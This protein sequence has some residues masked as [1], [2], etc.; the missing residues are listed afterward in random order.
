MESLTGK[1]PV[2]NLRCHPLFERPSQLN[3]G[4]G[5]TVRLEHLASAERNALL[6]QL[7]E[8]LPNL[9]QDPSPV[10]ALIELLVRPTN[11][12]F[13]DILG[14]NPP[15]DFSA[16]LSAPH[17]A[18]NLVTLILLHKASLQRS[19]AGI[20]AG[21]PNVVSS[22]VRLWLSTADIAVAQKAH[23]VLLGLLTADERIQQPET[24]AH[25]NLREPY[26]HGLMWR[27]LFKDKDIYG[28]MFSMC[29]LA[30]AGQP[31]QLSKNQKSAAQ[32]RLLDM[33]VRLD[34]ESIRNSQIPEVEQRYGIQRGGILDF[35]ATAM[36]DRDDVLMHMLLVDFYAELLPP[37]HS[38]VKTSEIS[39]PT[40]HSSS[41][42]DFLIDRGLHSRSL[43]YYLEP[44]RHSSMDVTYL[45]SRSANYLSVYA[46]L[47]PI[48]FL[49]TASATADATLRRLSDVF[50]RMSAATWAHAQVPTHDLHVLASLPRP[51]LFPRPTPAP[52]LFDIPVTPANADAYNVLATVFRGPPPDAS[53]D[54]HPGASNTSGLESSSA[55]AL[56][57]LYLEQRPDMWVH[58][59]KAAETVA[60]KDVAIAAIG[61]I[62][63]VITANW[64]LLSESISSPKTEMP[65]EHQL[66]ERCHTHQRLPLSGALAMLTSP[67]LETVLPFLFRPPRLFSN[68]V[69]GGKG[70]VESAAYLVAA[71]KYATAKRLRDRVNELV[72]ET[73][74][75]SDVVSAL[76]RRLAVGIMGGTGEVGGRVGTLEL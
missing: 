33:L 55:R 20:V 43:S 65:T 6:N 58:I 11:Y 17:S 29:D 30:T 5:L 49:D 64:S 67:S 59:V 53:Q 44:N 37:G 75:F 73:G 4:L 40:P 2:C 9:Q 69:G 61:L 1:L 36:V 68:L 66:S 63:A 52:P 71:A 25:E 16:G 28:S 21:K 26:H 70:D 27:R 15:V 72:E 22:L 12:T 46:S 42:L 8:L 3:V 50:F 47:Y 60:I 13:S 23:D 14:I 74:Q 19:D 38:E 57:F 56:Y 24:V 7:S 10:T 48:H 54:V 41:S 62:D 31:E 32:A 51:T 39:A 76:N 18:I 34:C 45:Y 35:A